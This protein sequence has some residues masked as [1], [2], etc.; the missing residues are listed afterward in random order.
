MELDGRVALVTGA[1]RNIG[2]AIALE[3]AAAGAK[4]VVNARSSRAD[5]EAVADEI[6]PGGMAYLADVTDRAAVEAMIAATLARFGRLDILVNGAAHPGGLEPDA[7]VLD[8]RLPPEPLGTGRHGRSARLTRRAASS[9]HGAS[10]PPS[11]PRA[12]R[13]DAR[14][15]SRSGR[16]RR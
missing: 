2:R 10:H 11:P 15:R 5:I 8:P 12:R 9:R 14:P 7:T 1:A 6:G 3:L 16:R 4:V 13:R